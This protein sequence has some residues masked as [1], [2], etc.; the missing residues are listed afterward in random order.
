M[1]RSKLQRMI[2]YTETLEKNQRSDPR[3]VEKGWPNVDQTEFQIARNALYRALWEI[4][5][6][7]DRGEAQ[8]EEFKKKYFP[9]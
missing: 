7:F 6:A 9:S 8:A 5:K 2:E 4:E 1:F 3:M